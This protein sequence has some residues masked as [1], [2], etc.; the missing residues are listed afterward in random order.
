MRFDEIYQQRTEKRLTVEQAAELLGVNERTFRR[1]VVRYEAEGAEGL[2]D[3]RLAK[4]V[5]NAAAVDEV[6]ALLVLFESH[7]RDWNVS[8]FHD[9][10]RQAHQGSRSYSWVKKQLQKSGL[11]K[12]AKKRGA[13]RR[14]RPRK[15]MV[16]MMLHQDGSTH[17]W[18]PGEYWDLIVTLDD[19][20]SHIY[21]AFFVDEE[22]TWSSFQGVKDVIVNHGLFCSLYVDRGSHYFYT[23]TVGGKVDKSRP[24]QFGRAMKQLGIDLIAAYS[25]EARGRSERF[26]GT[27][28]GRLPQE[29]GAEGITDMAQ[30]NHFLR[31][32]FIPNFNARFG[33][34]PQEPSSAFVVY[35]NAIETLDEILCLQEERVVKKD[36]T[37]SY[38]GQTLQIPGDRHRFSYAKTSVN[39][40]AYADGRMAI[41]HGPRCL[42]RYD[43]QSEIEQAIVHK[44]RKKAV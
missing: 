10:Y 3:G 32:Q 7:Y 35:V 1:W 11:V 13:H 31:E 41:F 20:N 2:A 39:V 17:Q 27:L 44:Q 30:A 23:P 8:H 15:P 37:I 6:T 16:G 25:P 12:Q 14:K 4:A 9:K 38:K 40:H 36:N 28:Q 22:G 19:A 34:E 33:V 26:F 43:K 29:L 21:S 24:T 18:I 42:G 5:H